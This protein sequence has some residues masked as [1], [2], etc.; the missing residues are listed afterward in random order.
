MLSAGECGRDALRGPI[1]KLGCAQ[2]RE[3]ARWAG[4]PRYK[5]MGEMLTGFVG[6]IE[7]RGRRLDKPFRAPFRAA[8]L[9]AGNT[10]AAQLR[11]V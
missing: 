2:D 9:A 11:G 6:W 1:P 10:N 4:G 3:A 7:A 8:A 5:G